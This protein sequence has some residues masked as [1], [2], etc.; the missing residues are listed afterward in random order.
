MKRYDIINHFIQKRNYTSFL[1]IGTREGE[2][3]NAV[4]CLHKVSVDPDPTTKATYIATSDDYFAARN[5]TFDIIFIDGDHRC[6]QVWR[7]IVN[8]L[9]HLNQNGMII[10]HDCKPICERFQRHHMSLH[11]PNET[12]NGDCWK[13]FLRAKS[14]FNYDMYIIDQ[15]EGCGV[16]DTATISTQDRTNIPSDMS[17]MSWNDYINHPEWFDFTQ[18]VP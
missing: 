10:M 11:S 13:A 3:F 17:T 6:G 16:I 5:D 1:E 8:S 2:T 18:L 9:D 15:D 14:L 4:S 7:D 12:W